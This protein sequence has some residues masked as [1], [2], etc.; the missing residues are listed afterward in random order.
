MR[1]SRMWNE[2][3]ERP[4]MKPA[5]HRSITFWA[6]RSSGCRIQGASY[7]VRWHD[8]ALAAGALAFFNSRPFPAA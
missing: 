8:T 7:G 2:V 1:N 4:Q 5:L 6:G 3:L